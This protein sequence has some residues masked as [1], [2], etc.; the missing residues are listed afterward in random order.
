LRWLL[1][2]ELFF[3]ALWRFANDPEIAYGLVSSGDFIALVHELEGS[4]L[5]WFWQRYLYRAE[6]PSWRM[7]RTP[8]G[9][10][11]RI[12][13]AWDDPAFELPLPLTV[14]G[15]PRRLAMTG[16]RASFTVAPGT[17]VE[18]DPDGRVL[19]TSTPHR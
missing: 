8:D 2:D 9:G 15:E 7:T 4:E 14:A 3:E 16:G 13:V 10:A 1:G 17:V 5:D 18:V 19:A 11:E 12:E 6:I